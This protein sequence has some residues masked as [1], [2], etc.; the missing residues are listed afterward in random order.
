MFG[1]IPF[2]HFAGGMP[3]GMGG[4]RGGEDFDK[5]ELYKTLGVDKKASGK[6]IRKAYMRLS[7][8]HHPD[9]GGDE[10]KFKEI[11][12][13]Y[14]ILSDEDRRAQYDKGVCV[15]W[16]GFSDQESKEMVS[17]KGKQM[18]R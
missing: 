2:E 13:A 7:R 6:D 17:R 9:K 12:A 4:S 8:E 15:C 10:R 16:S 5:T 18:T 1:G 11:S 3:G 14:A